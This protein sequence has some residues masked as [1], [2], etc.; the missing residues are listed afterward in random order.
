MSQTVTVIFESC[1]ENTLV[2]NWV[3]TDNS[4]RLLMLG[5]GEHAV[6]KS[7]GCLALLVKVN[8]LL[9]FLAQVN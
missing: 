9:H 8:I 6:L 4:L 5:S 3:L 2:E 7:N 1:L